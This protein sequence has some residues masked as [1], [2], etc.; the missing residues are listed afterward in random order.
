[1]KKQTR[2]DNQLLPMSL[3][4][5]ERRLAGSEEVVLDN[6]TDG[7]DWKRDKIV[8]IVLGFSPKMIDTTY[9]PIRHGGG[10]NL[11]PVKVLGAIKSGF[12]KNPSIVVKGFNL[13]FDMCMLAN[14]GISVNQFTSPFEDGSINAFLLNELQRSFSLDNCCEIQGVTPKLGAALYAHLAAKFG[15]EANRDQMKHFWRLAGDDP[16]AVDYAMGDSVSTWELIESQQD[17]L[18]DQDLRHIW[19]I[20]CRCIKVLVRMQLRG[21]KVNEE[22]LHQVRDLIAKRCEAARRKLPKDF[23]PRAPTN[24]KK[25]LLDNGI[26]MSKWLMTEGGAAKFKAG[27]PIEKV[28]FSFPAEWLVQFP[29]GRAVVDV[30]KLE[31]LEN[32]FLTPMIERH[33]HKGR[34]HTTYNQTRG[35]E[36]GTVTGRLSS[37]NP[38]L[39]QIHKR[40]VMLGSCFRSI[41]VPDT[42]MIMSSADYEQI[43]PRLLA[44]YGDVALLIKGYL[45]DPPIDAHSMV[46]INAFGFDPANKSPENKAKRQ[47][48]KTLNQALITGSGNNA[49]AAQ[50]KLPMA[51]AMKVINGY[52]AS[53]PEIK[54]TQTRVKNVFIA[55]RFLTSLLGRRARLDDTRFAYRGLNRLLQCGNADVIKKSMCDIDEFFFAEGDHVHLLNNIHDDLQYQFAKEHRKTYERALEMMADFGPNG[56]SVFVSVPLTVDAKEGRDWA[57]ASYGHADVEQAF[58]DMGGVYL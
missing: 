12:K 53:M 10:A 6:E 56:Q 17:S 2:E 50:L 9:L 47:F 3:D 58:K 1:M 48:G 15:G 39:Q 4:E 43:E 51:E 14:E 54:E 33:L 41:F 38:N 35:E 5:V 16:V 7:L 28:N 25:L 26:P 45:A 55:R 27:T 46:A 31:H 21:V 49:A 22:R 30:R 44:H 19:E 40:D 57:E 20:E 32:S 29:I 37:S 36:F 13:N 42:G 11:D 52:F 8:G 18:D 34:I 24:M 23:N